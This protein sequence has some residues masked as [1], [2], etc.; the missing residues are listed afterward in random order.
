[1]RENRPGVWEL[2]VTVGR[3]PD[4]GKFRRV[5][6]TVRGGKAQAARALAAFVAEVGD[7]RDL[8]SRDA[9][10]ITLATLV[11]GFLHHL[12]DHKGLKHSTLVHYQGLADTWILPPL[13]ERRADSLLPQDVEGALAAMRNAGQSRQSSIHQAFTLLNGTFKWARRNR[14]VARSPMSEAE[15]PRST[16]VPREV[17][18][19]NRTGSDGGSGYWIPTPAGSVCWSA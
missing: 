19:L 14:F 7:G 18:P 8:P 13:G 17:V 12:R 5:F 11:D 16:A 15:E 10:G 9:Q 4:G 6:R 2:S 3:E 1:M